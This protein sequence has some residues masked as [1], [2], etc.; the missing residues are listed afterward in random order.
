M[1][2][3]QWKKAQLSEYEH[4][5]RGWPLTDTEAGR[6]LEAST[7]ASEMHYAE[8]V[9]GVVR[10]VERLALAARRARSGPA[11]A[12]AAWRA[13]RVRARG[14]GLMTDMDGNRIY[15]EPSR[16]EATHHMNEIRAALASALEDI[17]PLA[18]EVKVETAAAQPADRLS[19][20]GRIG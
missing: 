15:A 13:A 18:D 4:V 14:T 3:R 17:R 5:Q 12:A 19:N 11:A 9:L 7:Q 2:F 6:V 8:A 1:F 16:H 10:S 20:G